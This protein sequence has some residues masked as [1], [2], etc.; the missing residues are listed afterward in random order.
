MLRRTQPRR[1]RR[2]CPR[3]SASHDDRPPSGRRAGL[4][5]DVPVTK[6]RRRKICIALIR[7]AG[8]ES[9]RRSACPVR[10]AYQ[11]IW[12]IACGDGWPYSGLILAG[13]ISLL[14]FS[15]SVAMNFRN[16][17]GSAAR[18]QQQGRGCRDC[19]EQRR[20]AGEAAAEQ[21]VVQRVQHFDRRRRVAIRTPA[22]GRKWRAAPP[23][24]P[25]RLP[26]RA[27]RRVRSSVTKTRHFLPE[28]T[29]PTSR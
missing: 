13:R 4:A 2:Q 22:A 25:G 3:P 26:D 18:N 12:N 21:H 11:T 1:A 8:A 28:F 19:A 14:H 16:S 20:D 9:E 17:A 27:P 15:V 24:R 29:W 5:G 6:S 23:G 7:Y 10:F